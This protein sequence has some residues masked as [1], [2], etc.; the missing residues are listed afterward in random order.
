MHCARRGPAPLASPMHYSVQSASAYACA[1][2]KCNNTLPSLVPATKV[3]NGGA[4]GDGVT[5][6]V[7]STS[8]NAILHD[9]TF[10]TR[11]LNQLSGPKLA[12]MHALRSPTCSQVSCKPSCSSRVAFTPSTVSPWQAQNYARASCA[13]HALTQQEHHSPQIRSNRASKR[14][15]CRASASKCIHAACKALVRPMPCHAESWR[16]LSNFR[17]FSC[18]YPMHGEQLGLISMCNLLRAPQRRL[19]INI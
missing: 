2:M 14:L 8:Q 15:I 4:S 1:C 3:S 12:T 6:I 10:I 11:A 13:A 16:L 9:S 18:F 7:C 19:L 17:L 5:T